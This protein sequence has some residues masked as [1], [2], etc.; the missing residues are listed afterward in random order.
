[1]KE[2]TKE[3]ILKIDAYLKAEINNI[4]PN[5]EV[6]NYSAVDKNEF[7]PKVII[8]V[9][10]KEKIKQQQ[11]DKEYIYILNNETMLDT[12]PKI[13]MSN[14]TYN[15]I[16]EPYGVR[17]SY[18]DSNF[19]LIG[20]VSYESVKGKNFETIRREYM[21]L[22]F[23][24]SQNKTVNLNIDKDN[25]N[26]LNVYS[27]GKNRIDSI[28]FDY[29]KKEITAILC[30]CF[31]QKI[32][33]D[34]DINI[35]NM[36]IKRKISKA[37]TLKK[38]NFEVD[39]YSSL[40]KSIEGELD[41]HNLMTDGEIDVMNQKAFDARIDFVKIIAK[42]K[43]NIDNKNI[44]AHFEN[45]GD[46]FQDMIERIHEYSN[47]LKKSDKDKYGTFENR[48]YF[49]SNSVL[50]SV[51]SM[52]NLDISLNS[53]LKPEILESYNYLNKLADKFHNSFKDEI[54]QYKTNKSELLKRGL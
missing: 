10:L 30:N 6:V 38:N 3:E 2:I 1:M 24:T 17:L 46:F 8:P 9:I 13:V 15:V 31:I 40:I 16:Y 14:G 33:F 51:I 5:I 47:T 36:N 48:N 25:H 50:L 22:N 12:D 53:L 49:Y 39:S 37:L 43:N 27:T 54:L 41:L 45:I 32:V 11:K 42:E 35:K 20:N 4:D 21:R 26:L 29:E 7:L 23:S 18:F 52:K 28:D 19:E 44:Y 34:F